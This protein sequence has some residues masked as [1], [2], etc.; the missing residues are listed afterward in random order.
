[1][2]RTS[3]IALATTVVTIAVAGGYYGLVLYPQTQEKQI[4][5]MP[6]PGTLR[7]IHEPTPGKKHKMIDTI[8]AANEGK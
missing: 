2:N 8:N 1:M 4:Y 7:Y 6:E 5:K 3:K